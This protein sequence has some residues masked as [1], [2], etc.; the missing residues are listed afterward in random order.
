MAKKLWSI[1]T[2]DMDTCIL[3]GRTDHVEPHHIF[4]GRLGLKTKSEAYGFIIPICA[5]C[6]PNGAF[7][8]DDNWKETEHRFKRACQE[9]YEENLGTREDWYREFGQFY[10]W[11]D[12]EN[13]TED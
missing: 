4:G 13:E 1:F 6:H 5:E 10:D 8:T 9:Y 3:T 12:I 7:C 11:E 2:D